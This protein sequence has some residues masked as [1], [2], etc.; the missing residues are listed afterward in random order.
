[1]KL[2]SSSLFESLFQEEL[3]ERTLNLYLA[4]LIFPERCRISWYELYAFL[5]ILL[6]QVTFDQA[7][8]ERKALEQGSANLFVGIVS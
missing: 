8:R 3:V 4:F 1:M 5:R 6:S 2:I 7:V